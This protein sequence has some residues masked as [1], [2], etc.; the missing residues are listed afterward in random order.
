MQFADKD[1][2]I[3]QSEKG[4]ITSEIFLEYFKKIEPQL[5]PL[6]PL[7]LFVDGHNS[8]FTPEVIEFAVSKQIHIFCYPAHLTH[9]LQPLDLGIFGPFKTMY[10]ALIEDECYENPQ[11]T[12]PER[13]FIGKAT[14]AWQNIK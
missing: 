12:I 14:A 5:P 13:I 3:V 4:W 8:H 11:T 1:S 6:R 2:L 9:R 7:F 10:R